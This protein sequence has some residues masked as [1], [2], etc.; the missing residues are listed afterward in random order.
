MTDAVYLTGILSNGNSNIL[1]VRVLSL[2]LDNNLIVEADSFFSPRN[3]N[4]SP[5]KIQ[6]SLY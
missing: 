5:I 1:K 6:L 2:Y 3:S 4:V